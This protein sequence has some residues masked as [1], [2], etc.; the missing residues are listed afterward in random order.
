MV[1]T[2]LT[3]QHLVSRIRARMARE[4]APRVTMLLML[5]LSGG[6]AFLT[7][8]LWLR[9]G[10]DSMAIRYPLAA[11]AGYC[12]F[13]VLA[14]VWI[15]ARRRSIDPLDAADLAHA[16]DQ[17]AGTPEGEPGPSIAAGGRSGG[18]GASG[19]W[20]DP[21][22]GATVPDTFDAGE[23]W[24]LTAAG[25]LAFAGL[26]AIG[27][28]VYAAPVLLAE[29]ALDAAVVSTVYG[30]LRRQD[31]SH[32]AGTLLRHTWLPA[33]ALIVSLALAGYVLQLFVPDARS[34]GGVIRALTE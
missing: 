9:A 10:L 26:V 16:P 5:A 4:E 8:F 31:A 20:G 32:W 30:R 34:I 12:A 28:V 2:P 14:R 3:R 7:S 15:A 25:A 13:I 6:F 11:L 22:Q 24:Y 1:G 29:I 19:S 21:D 27:Y 17:W 23:A 33:S 18:A